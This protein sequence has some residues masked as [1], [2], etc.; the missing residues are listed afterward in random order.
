M[1]FFVLI[2]ASLFAPS[3]FASGK[4]HHAHEHG[5]AKL[6]IVVEGNKATAQLEVPSESI[7]GFEYEAKS[8][9]DVAKRD[10]E[11]K[12]LTELFGTMLVF[13]PALK[14]VAQPG[15]IAPFVKDDHEEQ[16]EEKA[17]DK[18]AAK[19]AAQSGKAKKPAGGHSEHGTHSEVHAEFVFNCEQPLAGSKVSF[20]FGKV[21]PRIKEIK[22]QVLNDKNQVGADIDNDKGSVQL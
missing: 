20:A 1:R 13:D 18:P 17:H 7:Y 15:K 5:H 9:K 6:N 4:G 22:V 3:L 16:A 8:A 11:V 10:S 12:K 21:F 2:T 14:C 19:G